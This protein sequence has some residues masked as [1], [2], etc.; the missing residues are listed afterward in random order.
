M[1]VQS[2]AV[3]Q[4]VAYPVKA[5]YGAHRSGAYGYYLFVCS[6]QQLLQCG[7]CYFYPFGMHVVAVHGLC[8]YRNKGTCT[9]MQ[10][11]ERSIDTLCRQAVH[12]MIC[13]VQ[14]GS[15]CGY[16]TL[17]LC[18]NGLVGLLIALLCSAAQVG[19]QRHLARMVQHL[20]KGEC[21][22]APPQAQYIAA[23]QAFCY[24][25]I[26]CEG[27]VI[28]FHFQYGIVLPL[29]CTT[30]QAFPQ[31]FSA[32]LHGRLYIGILPVRCQAKDLYGAAGAF[33][34][35]QPCMHHLGLIEDHEGI[36]GN[37]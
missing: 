5:F 8:L 9:N 11:N 12:N 16:T 26:E 20:C 22:C 25:C 13:E 19:W 4:F 27:G 15:G 2:F 21:R 35:E 31:H 30:H 37:M 24:G 36:C 23:L 7:L 18:K 34:E 1:Q 28:A 29:G 14:S 17:V 10:C 33:F 32:L 3:Q 6:L